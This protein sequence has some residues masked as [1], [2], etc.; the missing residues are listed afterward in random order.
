MPGIL[1]EEKGKYYIDCKNAQWETGNIHDL[2]HSCGLPDI[3]CDADFAIETKENTI[4]L[5]EYKNANIPEAIAHASA[6]KPYDPFEQDKS[7]KLIRKFYDSLHYLRLSGKEK[8][9]DYICLLEYPNGDYISR[10]R[11]RNRLKK[12]LPFKLQEKFN[13]GIKLIESVSVVNIDEWNNHTVYGQFPIK[14]MDKQET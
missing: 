12:R 10:K 7:N 14:P 3:L 4:L 5:I 11:L 9:V 2:Y 13:T 6:T 8:P 1:I